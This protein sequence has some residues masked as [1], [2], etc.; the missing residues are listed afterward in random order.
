MTGLQTEQKT[1]EMFPRK[2]NSKET[3]GKEI[4]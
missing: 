1:G 3:D 4:E 2:T